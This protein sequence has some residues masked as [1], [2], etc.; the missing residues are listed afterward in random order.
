MLDAARELFGERGYRATSIGDV[1]SRAGAASGAF[2]QHFPSK[3]HLLIVLMQEFIDRLGHL[4]L[5]PKPATDLRTGL[6]QFLTDAFRV[7]SAYFGVVRAWQEASLGDA[8]LDRMQQ[9][10]QLWTEARV[11]GF[12][13][14]LQRHPDAL[15]GRDLPAFARMMDRHFWSLLA[16]GAGVTTPELAREAALA[17]DVIYHYLFCDSRSKVTKP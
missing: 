12:F 15:A 9:E 7:D 5:R 8:E 6:R 1:T 3:K 2:Y 10:I 11:L 4:E 16:R 17:A 14:H 13:E